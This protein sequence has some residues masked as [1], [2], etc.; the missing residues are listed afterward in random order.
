MKKL[1]MM[2]TCIVNPEN[3]RDLMR[4]VDSY[5]NSQATYS[6]VVLIQ[7]DYS[8]YE[9]EIEYIKQKADVIYTETMVSL[10]RAR[11]IIYEYAHEQG[12][13]DEAEIIA[14]PDDDCWYPGKNLDNI[15]AMFEKDNQ[16]DLFVCLSSES[17]SELDESMTP[18]P[19][20]VKELINT[21]TSNT[22]FVRK[23]AL[24]KKEFFDEKLGIGS[25]N[26]GGEDVDFAMR[27]FV[28][29]RKSLYLRT[30]IVWHQEENMGDKPR[31][32][33]GG[34]K[35][36]KKNALKHPMFA[37]FCFRKFLVGVYYMMKYGMSPKMF[38]S[39]S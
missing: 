39:A 22:I 24:D 20:T 31:Y 18:Q 14:F 4:M 37:V 33:Q 36:L 15:Y 21:A 16:L 34:F 26:N 1:L 7:T 10:S 25:V 3:I 13:L 17:P 35:A 11:N 6:H 9:K 32:F 29:S 28:K 2:T 8:G 27:C 19:I 5:D 30:A 12:L 23:C 38:F